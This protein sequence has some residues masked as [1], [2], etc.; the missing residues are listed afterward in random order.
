MVTRS[1][2]SIPVSFAIIELHEVRSSRILTAHLCQVGLC[3][4]SLVSVPPTP[5]EQP[6][7]TK[8]YQFMCSIQPLFYPLVNFFR[9]ERRNINRI[10]GNAEGIHIGKRRYVSGIGGDILQIPQISKFSITRQNPAY[11]ENSAESTIHGN[12]DILMP[13]PVSCNND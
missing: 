10:R 12:G 1:T 13:I 11:F 7:T 5:A 3:H 8:V 6:S 9:R 2:H 4:P